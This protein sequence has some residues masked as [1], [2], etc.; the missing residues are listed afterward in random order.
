MKVRTCF[1]SNS[2]SSSFVICMKKNTEDNWA[3]L[4]ENY[5]KMCADDLDCYDEEEL[6][7][8]EGFTLTKHLFNSIKEYENDCRNGY[9][10][11]RIEVS[12][13][14]S[15]DEAV[16]NIL[17]ALNRNGYDIKWKNEDY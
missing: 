10:L 14:E 2:S 15:P 12:S 17:N 3:S 7:T 16:A 5:A 4:L 13:E 1:V 8:V 6:V 11:E 9:T